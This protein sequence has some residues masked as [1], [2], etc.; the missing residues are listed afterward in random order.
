MGTEAKR[1]LQ[2][3]A[4]P[5]L[6][7]GL[8]T[9][10]IYNKPEDPIQFLE[11]AIQK[12]RTNPG[13]AFKWDSFV[14][15]PQPNKMGEEK[16]ATNSSEKGDIGTT[17][18]SSADVDENKGKNKRGAES[19][20]L[21][22]RQSTDNETADGAR[23]PVAS[24]VVAPHATANSPKS[25]RRISRDVSHPSRKSSTQQQN[26][27]RSRV[28]SWSNSSRPSSLV[29]AAKDAYI[30][31][32]A[33]IILF[34]G[35][36][37]GGKTRYAA[38]L[39]E[40]LRDEGLA[41]ICMPDLIRTSIARYKDR[42]SEW[43]VAAER[44]QR[45][46]LIPNE[47]AQQ[48]VKAEMGRQPYAKAYF[49][50]GFPRE[51]RQVEDFERNVRPVD[52]ALIL[53]YD[54]DVLRRHMQSRGLFPEVI[55]RRIDEFKQ[56]TLPSAK[57][58]DDQRLLHLIP[59]EKDDAL[60]IERM[61]KL[62][63]RAMRAGVGAGAVTGTASAGSAHSST[64]GTA[65][66]KTEH[67]QKNAENSTKEA[68]KVAA[69]KSSAAE[70]NAPIGGPRP[71]TMSSA[72]KSG[73]YQSF[74]AAGGRTVSATALKTMTK[75]AAAAVPSP[76]AKVP[77]RDGSERREGSGSGGGG[78][79]GT[80]QQ[81][82]NRRSSASGGEWKTRNGGETETQVRKSPSSSAGSRNNESSKRNGTSHSASQKNGGTV[83]PNVPIV[84]VIGAPGSSKSKFAQNIAKKYDGFVFISMGELLR[85]KVQQN[86]ENELWT[87]IG[88]KM[89]AGEMIPMRICREL[90][91]ASVHERSSNSWGFVVEGFPRTLAQ[92]EDIEAQLG[93]IDLALLI[94]CTE[95]FC[96]DALRKRYTRDKE[97]GSERADD[98][99]GVVRIR[100]AQFKA[101]TLPMLKYLDDH[102]KLRVIEGDTN[103]EAVFINMCQIIENTIFI[104]D[105]G[106]G[107][108]LESSKQNSADL[109][110]STSEA[111][112]A[113][114]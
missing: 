83:P 71:K 45:G 8:M 4:I 105:D 114:E 5:Q 65:A 26:G 22:R 34:M 6:F 60:I 59:G 52:M 89:D 80:S 2:D 69:A 21:K 54:E 68:E 92:A 39:Q 30:A 64:G 16:T 43:R 24:S 109:L 87:K 7:E 13:M 63:V 78:N 103:E 44:Y 36:P 46:E 3:H 40:E 74:A 67:Q 51:A 47:L 94:D 48:L 100:M 17:T 1:Y 37:G 111:Q 66:G 10:L 90:I 23:P 107:K 84:L 75:A 11:N 73:Q 102:G 86:G 35:G 97:E 106:N 19:V 79:R 76:P 98:D 42:S 18:A 55:E 50:E 113:K 112:K 41:H 70:S 61:R 9:G 91:Y 104:Q 110:P 12:I 81:S 27:T 31:P 57:Y 15:P 56:K 108:S 53:D 99:E 101:N 62:V 85:R 95:Q 82:G 72:P 25:S 14:T 29:Q 77:S 88:K 49:I 96:K 33:P 28:N 38:K 20:A 58:F 93:H 32:D